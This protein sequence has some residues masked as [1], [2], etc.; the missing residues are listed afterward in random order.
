[1]TCLCYIKIK[2]KSCSWETTEDFKTLNKDIK[3]VYINTA[4]KY[5]KS[6]GI[7]FENYK[8]VCKKL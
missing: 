1:M 2:D 6:I 8:V 3:K 7:D 5:F 4:E